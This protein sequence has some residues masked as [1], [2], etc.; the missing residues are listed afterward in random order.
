MN[1]LRA[2]RDS[3][4]V[5]ETKEFGRI[6]KLFPPNHGWLPIVES[7]VLAG[8][9][10]AFVGRSFLPA[11]RNL[12]SDFPNYYLAASL[13]HRSIPLDRIYEWTWFQ[14]QNDHLGVRDGLVS[15][16]PNPP[17]CAVPILLLT[18]LGPLAAKRVWLVLNL[19]FLALALLMLHRVTALSWRRLIL[20]SLSCVVPLHA[21]FLFGQYYVLIL[22]LICG[23]YCASCLGH[24]FTAGAV[25]AAAAILKLFPV[26]FLIPFVWKRNW[27]SAAGLIFGA[28][29]LTA[30]SV[31][32]F[33]FEVHRVFLSEVMPQVPRGDWLGPYYYLQRSSFVTL[34]S[35]FFLFEPELN[36]SPLLDSPLLYALAQAATVVTLLLGF[37]LS[38]GK[39]ST[40][41]A[42]ALDWAALVPLSLLLSSQSG[43]YH[44]SVLI[45][46]AIV[47][48][49]SLA[50]TSKRKA[51][52]F[53]L[54]YVIACA[55]LPGILL[56]LFPVSRLGATTALYVVLLLAA[57]TESELHFDRRWLAAGLILGA[58]LA[59]LGLRSV[60]NR[61]E[62]FSRRLPSP[63]NG[64]R[65][66]N[67]A[68]M[69]GGVVFTEMQPKGYGA[70]F[71]QG[72]DFRDLQMPPGDVL[73]LAGSGT[74][75]VLYS[76]L[77]GHQSFIVRLPMERPGS[78][79]ETMTKGQEPALS[80]NG[81]WLAF[82]REEQGRS[83]VWRSATDST[84]APLMVLPS[85]YH[86]L[87]VS[88]TSE[89]DVIAAAGR[90]SDPH[91]FL[92]RHGTEVVALAEFPH[93]ARYPAVSPD[94]KRLA[95]SRRD[96]GSWH[97]VVRELPTGFEQQLTHASC[98]AISPSWE[99]A[100]TLL[101]A[102]DCGR[103][104]GLSAITRVVLQREP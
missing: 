14:R 89:G 38:I 101:Y 9:L 35:H 7:F 57:S 19:G 71:L 12:N 32:I 1:H 40:K 97:L 30:V 50:S 4:E 63:P 65:S 64:Y 27:R 15:F 72:G 60:R 53:L 20:I 39:S 2:A 67:P 92:V 47:G 100:Q 87:D 70:V 33:G 95:F 88:V 79:P 46:T 22:L 11:W 91:F 6:P 13:Y 90:V 98:N 24:R 76:E 56:K 8:L 25:L 55:P 37:L 84:D 54:L 21:N 29:L 49:D 93:P 59:L 58:I 18:D 102:T 42:L 16:A 34:W 48:F 45:F 81:K 3:A 68:P 73:S 85:T 26:L 103:G 78:A 69:A 36:P 31:G 61:T 104:V 41:R 23:A 44:P 80:P 17:M 99:T 10:A 43:I 51:L 62:D 28:A 52:I 83:T 82:I 74:T 75:P 5:P 77:T 96:Q 86:P 66:A 94:G